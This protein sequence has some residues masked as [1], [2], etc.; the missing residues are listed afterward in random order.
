MIVVCR[1][2]RYKSVSVCGVSEKSG[3][4]LKRIAFFALHKYSFFFFT[5]ITFVTFILNNFVLRI[6]FVFKSC[7]VFLL[8][9]EEN[10]IFVFQIN[11]W[12]CIN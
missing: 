11:K 8:G 7:A 1:V 3:N 2:T 9:M 12:L 5:C 10:T 4:V 6:T